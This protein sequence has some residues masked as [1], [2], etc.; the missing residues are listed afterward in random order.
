NLQSALWIIYWIIKEQKMDKFV[1]FLTL[2]CSACVT[3]ILCT[4]ISGSGFG[5]FGRHGY[6]LSYDPIFMPYHPS[7]GGYIGYSNPYY[8]FGWDSYGVPNYMAFEGVVL[9]SYH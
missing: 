9:R 8:R 4:Y 2:L 3:T 5:D 6:G 7:S 1:T